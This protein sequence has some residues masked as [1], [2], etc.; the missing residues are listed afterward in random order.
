MPKGVKWRGHS[1]YQISQRLDD[2]NSA[3]AAAYQI[4]LA[5]EERAARLEREAKKALISIADEL[6]GLDPADL[7]LSRSWACAD[8]PTDRCIY[9]ETK[10][11]W[12]NH[13]LF[14]EEP[15]DRG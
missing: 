9:N 10:D 6:K 3:R 4:K 7:Y 13:C 8:S 15:E 2:A 5:T 1:V 11:T 12:H 14:C